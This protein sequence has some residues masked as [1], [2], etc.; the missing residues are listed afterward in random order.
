M[1]QV[2]ILVNSSDGFE[3][4]WPP[5]FKLLTTYWPGLNYPVV[6]NTERKSFEY[7]ELNINPSRVNIHVD[8]KLTWSECLIAALNI[9]DTPLVLYM[10]EDYFIESPVL[11]SEIAEFSKLMIEN[12]DIKYIGLTHFG[13][14]TPFRDFPLDNRLKI[15]SQNSRY[16]ISTQAGLWRKDVLLSYLK[17]DENGWMFEIFGT[18]R[19]RKR[20]ELF[21]TANREIYN[22]NNKLI[23]DYAHTGIIKGKWHP[24]M[25]ALFKKHAI[26][27][28]FT[29][30]G[31]YKQK[32][33]F[34]RKVETV[35]KL[36]KNPVHFYRGMRG[37]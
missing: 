27:M 5:F 33:W 7:D 1:N 14:F 32:L 2:T 4:C 36:L 34:F 13:N 23:M 21:L 37:Q 25:P 29:L 26:L 9:I 35:N 11:T 19:A 16:R 8:R 20:N 31:I 18:Q 30:R 28:D 17:P 10:Q 6:L 22:P 12:S 24:K 3:D 15:V